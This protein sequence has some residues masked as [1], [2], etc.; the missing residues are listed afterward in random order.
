M[1]LN[2]TRLSLPNQAAGSKDMTTH[3]ATAPA[4]KVTLWGVLRSEAIRFFA[5]NSTRILIAVAF[6]VYLGIAAIATWGVGSLNNS[7]MA[8]MGEMQGMEMMTDPNMAAQLI[9]SGLVFSQLIL[10]VLGVLLFSGEFTTGS[11]VS[12]VLAS[13]QRF[14]VLVAKTILITLL[15]GIVQIAATLAAFA[16]CKPISDA[17]NL[18]LEFGSESFQKVLWFGALAVIMAALIGLALG[19]LLRNSAGGITSLAGLFFVLPI[20]VALLTA[21]TDWAQYVA[22]FM[23]DQLGIGL[24][25]PASVSTDLEQWQQLLGVAGWIVLPLALGAVLLAKRDIK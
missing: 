1:P 9:G 15:T 7:D 6:V 13:P 16:L 19:V 12:T 10:G 14:R 20:I 18:G 11:A 25:T 3:L 4:G 5:L 8:G 22:K 21:F 24:A 17:Y 2:T 23:P